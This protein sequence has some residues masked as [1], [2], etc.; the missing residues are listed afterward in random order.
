MQEEKNGGNQRAGVANTDPPDE[1][2]DGESP[3]DGDV[4]APD[5]DAFEEQIPDGV[6]HHHRHQEDDAETQ[7]PALETGRVST[8][9]LIFSVTEE[10]V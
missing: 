4:D 7:D 6:E 9:A 8:I 2:D 10:K 3:A 5:A 1:V